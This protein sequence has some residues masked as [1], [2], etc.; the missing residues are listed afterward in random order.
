MEKEEDRFLQNCSMLQGGT[1]TTYLLYH[2]F[3]AHLPSTVAAEQSLSQSPVA[4]PRKEF[5]LRVPD[6]PGS[7]LPSP[8]PSPS[9]PGGGIAA[10][11]PLNKGRRN[12]PAF[13]ALLTRVTH[14]PQFMDLLE[15]DQI[16]FRLRYFGRN[17]KILC[18]IHISATYFCRISAI[19]AEII[20]F[21][22]RNRQRF[23]SLTVV[24]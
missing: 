23:Q 24:L 20:W 7:P 9:S 19:S 8:L 6:S 22:C 13:L 3:R 15:N 5:K 1:Y 14:Y 12:I 17:G 16:L 10:I 18:F 2:S 4:A 21:P 11:L